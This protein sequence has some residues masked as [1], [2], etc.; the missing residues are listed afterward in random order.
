MTVGSGDFATFLT[1]LMRACVSALIAGAAAFVAAAQAGASD[2][3]AVY[4]AAAAALAVLSTR[5][6]GEGAIDQRRAATN[7]QSP[8]D[9]GYGLLPKEPTAEMVRNKYPPS[10]R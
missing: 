7:N 6:L 2:R 1:A 5:G 3:E 8:A 9:V 10:R 4:A